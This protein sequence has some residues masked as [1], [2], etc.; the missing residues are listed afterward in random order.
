MNEER[1]RVCRPIEG[2]ERGQLFAWWRAGCTVA[3]VS[4]LLGRDYA[5]VRMHLLAAGGFSPREPKVNA[6]HLTDDEREVISRCLVR[7]YG[8]R[9]IAAE[10]GR[11]PSTVSREINRNGGVSDYRCVAAQARALKQK[12]RPK[13]CK[14]ATNARL[15]RVV[16]KTLEWLWS[17]QQISGWL[18]LQSADPTMHISHEAIYQSLFIQT[19]GALKAELTKCLRTKRQMRHGKPAGTTRKGQIPGAVSISERPASVEDRAVP[20]H[21]EGDLIAGTQT[22]FIATLVERKTRFVILAKVESKQT[23]HVI[24][25][26]IREMKNLPSHLRKTLTLDRGSEFSD[27]SRFTIATDL[28][29]YFCDPRSPWQRGSNENTNGL[30][31][32]YF[33][34]GKDVSG[35]TQGQ[36]NRVA[37]SLNGRPRKTLGF[38]NPT[39]KLAELL[40]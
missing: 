23:E 38:H 15:R 25:A 31:R 35:Y 16:S 24:D 1:K 13:L 10:L 30:L 26:L 9:Q 11:S 3:Q 8:V 2:A 17:P 19:R 39:A 34:K 12:A 20:G 28:K 33:P 40:R 14:L 5:S 18:K 6:R 29:V 37:A 32:Q 27:H 7:R 21:W 36:L 22:S 4:D